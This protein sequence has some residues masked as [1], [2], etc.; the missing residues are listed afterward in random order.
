MKTKALVMCM[1]SFCT[2]ILH[3]AAFDK[4]GQSVSAFLQSG[5]YFEANLGVSDAEV[6]GV[7]SGTNPSHHSISDIAKTDYRQTAALKLQLTPQYSFGLLYDQPFG[8]DTEYT[9]VNGFVATPKDMVMLPGITTS[10]LADATSGHVSKGNTKAQLDI[11]NFS[12]IAG[13]QPNKNWN[14]FAGPVY[15]TFKSNVSLRGNVYSLYNGYDFKSKTVGDWGWLAGLAYQI[16]E[17]STKISLTYRSVIT[18]HVNATENVPLVD[19]LTTQQGRDLVSQHLDYM[20]S[21]GQMT[22]QKKNYL[23]QIISELPHSDVAAETKFK[24]PDS[25]N[26]EFQTGL[27]PRTSLFGS[28]RW[29]NWSDFGLQPY[30]FGEISKV[31]G[32]LSTPARPDGF[33]LVRYL[34]DQWTLNLG[35]GQSFSPKWLGSISV[36]WDSG[37]GEKV[38]T[39]GPVKGYYNLGIGAQYS[40]SPQYFISSGIKYYWLGDAKGQLGAQAG[41]DYYVEDFRDNHSIGYGLK[42]GYKF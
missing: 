30:R 31:L 11:Q 41:S 19:M 20:I 33:D 42:I 38:S 5:N 15:Q 18:H 35:I 2:N 39:A 21:I 26:L 1:A 40:P 9:G 8:A 24:S 25:V 32:G 4:T 29:V 3:A 10:T 7:E 36:G 13:Y 12:L 14:F 6:K 23:N 16:P 28:L 34:D 17:K 27:R 22:V 37:A